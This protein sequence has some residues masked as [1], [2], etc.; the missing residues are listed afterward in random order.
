[1]KIADFGL[2]KL[3]ERAGPDPALTRAEQVMGNWLGLP[4]GIWALVALTRPP[5]RSAFAQKSARLDASASVRNPATERAGD[6]P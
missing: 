6:A 3:L 4:I 1:M 5:I 2:A